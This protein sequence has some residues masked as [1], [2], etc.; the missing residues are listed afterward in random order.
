MSAPSP[1]DL[2]SQ[3]APVSDAEAA[4]AFGAAGREQLLDAITC[5]AP[6]RARPS[7]RLRRP[8]VV[9]L[10]ALVI[11]AA[12]GAGWA[13]THGSARETT[14]V[15]CLIDGQTTVINA[16]S[17]DPA[18]DCSA[19]W[20]A[21]APKLQAYDNGLGGVVVIPAS[22]KPQS[23]W[24]AIAS[25]DVALIEL[26]ESL[27]DNINGLDS[28]C[29]DANAATAFAQRQLDRL[30]LIGWAVEERAT[31]GTTGQACYG[32]FADPAARTVTLMSG[33]DQSGPSSWPPHQLA[34]SLRPLTQ[35]CLSLPAMTSQVEQRA[36]SLGMSQTVEDSHNYVLN[37]TRDD[38]MRCATVYETVGGTTDV[39][40]RGPEA[41]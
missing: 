27:D 38:T 31:S 37:S 1:I 25:Q 20:P 26:Q 4:G 21:P 30:G 36:T 17:G 29:F 11:A 6:G 39:I 40:L 10:A 33:G 41:P 19:I 7:R 15:D 23:S 16:T 3:I 24:T 8:V 13:L 12:T 35:D 28:S 5:T 9:A 32:G 18:S 2:L 14:A 34:S 22:Q